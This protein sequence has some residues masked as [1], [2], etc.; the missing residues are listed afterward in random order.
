MIYYI[1]FKE[2]KLK[3]KKQLKNKKIIILK[4]IYTKFKI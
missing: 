4:N 1:S 2:L 3:K